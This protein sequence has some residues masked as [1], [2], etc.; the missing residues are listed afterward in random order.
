M[1]KEMVFRGLRITAFAAV[2]FTS[3]SLFATQIISL[4]PSAGGD[5]GAMVGPVNDNNG[6]NIVL[7]GTNGSWNVNANGDWSN[8]ANWLSNVIADG[9]G[10]T[11]NFTF[12]L[13]SSAKIV[14]LDTNRTIGIIN[15][16]DS[17]SAFNSYT[18]STSNSSILTLDNSPNSANA[19]INKSVSTATDTISTAISLL[20]SLDLSNSSTGTLT[21]S[22]GITSGSAGAK[23]ITASS[24]NVTISGVVGDGSGSVALTQNGPGTLTLGSVANTYTGDTTINGGTISI[25]SG[26][27]PLGSGA[28]L[29]MAG[30]TLNTTAD[31]SVSTAA[32]AQNVVVS[33]DST[34]STTSAAASTVNLNFTGTLS[35]SAGTLTF[36]NNSTSSSSSNIFDP[37]FSGGDFT[38]ARPIVL[39]GNGLGGVTRFTDANPSA[40]TH[41]YSGVISGD[42]SFRR[43]SGA[44]GATFFL[45][46]NT[47]TGA[48]TI[49]S[50]TL[51]LGNGGTTGSLSP[52]SAISVGGGATLRF[53]H[54]TGADF[55][56]GTNFSSSAITGL[57]SIIKDG[58]ASLTFNVANTFSGGLTINKGTVVSSVDGALGTGNVSLTAGN[59]T[60]TLNGASNNIADSATLSFVNTDTINLNNSTTDTVAGLVVDGVSQ[61]PGVYG[62]GFNNPDNAFFGVGTITVVPEPATWG[63]ML[64]GGG[65][66][67]A[68]RRFRRRTS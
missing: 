10:A 13:A 15:I 8:S 37:R 54:T 30:G 60:L 56:Q 3:A 32:L 53:D 68:M 41:T 61:A 31:R 2:M 58:T 34:I 35:G 14:N 17:T 47:Y 66:L 43:L 55:V 63:M 65:L 9:A 57:G 25:A 51:Q 19:Q 40:T 23:T 4:A 6:G 44:T 50:G 52:S 59:I 1:K 7:T 45:A 24:G 11:A 36:K 27:T 22:G 21:L 16:G 48:T 5:G 26:G 62:N 29:N 39:S 67:T 64:L 12:N 33:A 46:D 42:G 38:M 49:N 18:I 20:S 28:N